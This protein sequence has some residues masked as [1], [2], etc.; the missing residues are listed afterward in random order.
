MPP[1]LSDALPQLT[2]NT[3]K[4]LERISSKAFF[5]DTLAAIRRGSTARVFTT[6]VYPHRN[7]LTQHANVPL[8]TVLG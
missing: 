1:V 2:F 5:A 4:G 3:A 6:R 8:L 7:Q